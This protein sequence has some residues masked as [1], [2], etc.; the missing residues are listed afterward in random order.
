MDYLRTVEWEMKQQKEFAAKWNV[1]PVTVWRWKTRW[2]KTGM[3]AKCREIL[4]IELFEDVTVANRKAIKQWDS[5]MAEWINL[6]HNARRED[7]RLN[8]I[9][10]MYT[11]IVKPAQDAQVDSGSREKDYLDMIE[12]SDRA[13]EPM[14][15]VG[16]LTPRKNH[17]EL[18]AEGAA[19]ATD[20]NQP[21]VELSDQDFEEDDEYTHPDLEEV[22]TPPKDEPL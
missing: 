19:T 1:D 4:G 15:V 12:L 17:L 11:M 22:Q 2:T 18:E 13:L 5:M 10:S 6:A 14:S 16:V 9:H 21:D 8:A 20:E 7:V 3:L